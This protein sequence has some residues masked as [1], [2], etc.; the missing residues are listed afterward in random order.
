MNRIL[1]MTTSA[2]TIVLLTVGCGPNRTPIERLK[3]YLAENK[4]KLG[5][6]SSCKAVEGTDNLAVKLCYSVPDAEVPGAPQF[7]AGRTY[8]DAALLFREDRWELVSFVYTIFFVEY[9][10][11]DFDPADDHEAISKMRDAITQINLVGPEGLEGN[12]Y[13]SLRVDVLRSCAEY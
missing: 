10:G 4:S 7:R 3:S 6:F 13:R 12:K 8:V 9:V 5:H 2:L 11:D 1:A